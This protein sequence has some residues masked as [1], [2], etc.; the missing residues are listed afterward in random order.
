MGR[1][2]F[3]MP[4][5]GWLASPVGFLSAG[6]IAF[7]VDAPLSLAIDSVLP[8][9]KVSTTSEISLNLISPAFPG[10]GNLIA[11]AR[12]ID[13]SSR[14]GFSEVSVNDQ[15][16]RLI[17]HATSRCVIVDAPDTDAAGQQPV[18]PDWSDDGRPDPWLEQP[19]GFVDTELDRRPGLETMQMFVAGH[20]ETPPVANLFGM[21][22]TEVDEGEITWTASASPWWSSPGPYLYG[23]ALGVLADVAQNTAFW[24]LLPAGMAYANLDL[25]IQFMR[26][27]FADGRA[28]TARGF[29][30]HRGRS[31]MVAGVEVQNA[32]GKTVLFGTG[33]AAVL[34]E[35]FGVLLAQ[36]QT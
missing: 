25:K 35:G 36:Q 22:P 17:A 8:A 23:G 30:T 32:D 24:T 11:R 7:L 27:A 29:V 4:A 26:P 2:T 28:L 5:S 19:Q 33:S 15:H 6:P 14:L 16:G 31:I 13:V 20:L 21:R 18:D 3:A 12:V 1:A 34:P 9:G 10:R